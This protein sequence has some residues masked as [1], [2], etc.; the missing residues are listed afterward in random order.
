MTT[1]IAVALVIAVALAAAL[2]VTGRESVTATLVFQINLDPATA[3]N[4]IFENHTVTATVTDA[5]DYL[6]PGI[7]VTF[8]VTSGPNIGAGGTCS[9]ADCTTDFGP[10]S[11]TYTSAGG[12]GTDLIQACF[13][14]ALYGVECSDPVMKDWVLPPPLEVDIDIKPGGEPN[15]IRTASR[16]RI[17][18]AI[19]G[20]TA[21]PFNVT[22]VDV[23][24]LA[25]GPDG[26]AP[27]SS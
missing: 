5:L 16:G 4:V 21:A 26:A 7:L 25:F 11:F 10:V 9:P 24:T 19:L 17:P 18:V 27:A 1:K 20:G 2:V 14:D 3:E 12:V 23:T 22:D 6:P 13:T 15:S 8:S